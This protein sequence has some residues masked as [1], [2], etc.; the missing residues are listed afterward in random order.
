MSRHGSPPKVCP[1]LVRALADADTEDIEDKLAGIRVTENGLATRL[2][3]ARRTIR[4][5]EIELRRRA[6]GGRHD[7]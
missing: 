4:A 5:M 2:N 1:E 6:E 7:A 3:A